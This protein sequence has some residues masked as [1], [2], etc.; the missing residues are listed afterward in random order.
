MDQKKEML[1]QKLEERNKER[2]GGKETSVGGGVSR[3]DVDS[4]LEDFESWALVIS[5]EVI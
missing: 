5:K 3:S 1:M 4:L 2:L